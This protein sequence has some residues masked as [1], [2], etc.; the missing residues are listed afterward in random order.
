[1]PERRHRARFRDRAE[2][3]DFLLE[4]TT[5]TSSAPDLD[6][7]LSSV[8]DYVKRVVPSEV[9]AILIYSE[10]AKGLK[11]RHAIG[12]SREKTSTKESRESPRRH[13]CRFSPGTQNPIHDTCPYSTRSKANWQCR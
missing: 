5:T 1:M 9:V 7:L 3:L 13:E 12:L 8:S 11:V 6:S 2:L 10:R 4:V